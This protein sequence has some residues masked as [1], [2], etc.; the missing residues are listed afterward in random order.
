MQ[1]LAMGTA[2][3]FAA[4]FS[5]TVFSALGRPARALPLSIIDLVVS[6]SL[7]LAAAQYGIM[8]AAIVWSVR[9]ILST[10]IL[11]IMCLRILPI[12]PLEIAGA[13]WQPILLAAIFAA[14][15]WPLDHVLLASVLP[16]ARIIVLAPV[17]GIMLIL[18]ISLFRPDL[19][20]VVMGQL[21][22]GTPAGLVSATITEPAKE[23][24]LNGPL[25][26]VTLSHRS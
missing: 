20:R 16:L 10:L 26:L 7:L 9:Q 11:L 23:V 15:L 1:I 17:G 4:L 18:G 14:L 21:P 24:Q 5:Y 12:R 22:F 13:L 25:L 19:V 6:I 2:G 8:A 3:G